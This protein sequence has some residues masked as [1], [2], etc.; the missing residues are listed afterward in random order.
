ME[1]MQA[2]QGSYQTYSRSPRAVSVVDRSLLEL[3]PGRFQSRFRFDQGG[4]YSLAI[5]VDQ[6]RVVQCLNL[7]VDD[8]G[9]TPSGQRVGLTYDPSL[10]SPVVAGAPT[11]VRIRLFNPDVP[12]EPAL[13]EVAD[14]Q[15][16]ALELPGLSQQRVF[17]TEVEPGVYEATVRFPRPGT[18][19]LMSQVASKGLSFE[20]APV[21]EIPVRAASGGKQ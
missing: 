6:P 15:I 11:R 10:A 1:G 4:T 9:L 17:L 14:L 3:S 8:T 21:L 18:W 19:R 16:M 13:T 12:G 20:R 5:L 7:K 2:P